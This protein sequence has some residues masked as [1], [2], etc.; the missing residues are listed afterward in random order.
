MR[1]KT[2]NFLFLFL[3]IATL[4]LALSCK[5]KHKRVGEKQVVK[6]QEEIAVTVSDILESSLDEAEQKNGRINGVQLREPGVIKYIYSKKEFAPIWTTDSTW[7]PQADSILSFIRQARNYGLFPEDYNIRR[8]DTLYRKTV[9]DP[10]KETRLDASLWAESELLLSSALVNII[11]DLKVGRLMADSTRRKDSSMSPNFYYQQFDSFRLKNSEEFAS[12]L[13]PKYPAYARLQDALRQFLSKAKFRSYTKIAMKDS[14]DFSELIPQRLAEDSIFV[15]EDTDSDSLAMAT[16]IKK[17]QN[18]KG[19]RADGK[20]TP[21]LLSVLNTS[22]ADR[23]VQI[24]ITLDRYK[25][26]PVLPD[27]YVWVNIPNYTLQVFEG[28]SVVLKSKVVVGKPE[29]KTPVLSSSMTDMITYPLWHIP[30]SIIEKDVLPALKRDAGYLARKGFS[31]VDDNGDE[32]DP[33]KVKWAKYKKEIPYTVIQGSGDD[34]ALGVIKFNFPNK[35]SV[36]LHDTNQRQFFKKPKR[37]LS[38]G[39]VRVE[40]WKEL[41]SYL[42]LRDSL[43]SVNAVK[44]DSLNTWLAKKQKRYVPLRKT[45]PLYIRYVTCEGRDG[46]LVT[47]DDVYGDDRRLRQTYFSSK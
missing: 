18:R 7:L 14:L 26:I 39:C 34:N 13:E 45:M 35:F 38:H 5:G 6:K 16:A 23:F 43:N 2:P 46:K 29:T 17:Y 31:L 22:D 21:E 4:T 20:I 33:Y 44:I 3:F 11:G 25:L 47:Y 27:N 36:Y 19:L 9:K 37:A 40:A 28:D 1:A 10:N 41:A 30:P 15:K 12:S 24:A 8:L 42:L 32:V